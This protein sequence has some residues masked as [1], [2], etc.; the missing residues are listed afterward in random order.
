MDPPKPQWAL[1]AEPL[2]DPAKIA[3]LTGAMGLR[4]GSRRAYDLPGPRLPRRADA[5]RFPPSVIADELVAS[6]GLL[7]TLAELPSSGAN[8]PPAAIASKAYALR[9]NINGHGRN[10]DANIAHMSWCA[11]GAPVQTALEIQ[12]S[13]T[14]RLVDSSATMNRGDCR[15][16]ILW[17]EPASVQGPLRIHVTGVCLS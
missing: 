14:D 12:P 17:S 10:M 9:A 3:R 2:G 1:P 15:P 5:R 11:A 6:A 7:E 16:A 8:S 4:T 13:M